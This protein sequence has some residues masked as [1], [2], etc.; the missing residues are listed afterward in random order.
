MWCGFYI[1]KKKTIPIENGTTYNDN[2]TIRASP[3]EKK[4]LR[5][6]ERKVGQFAVP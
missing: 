4:K 3:K 1:N 2:T 5:P 6:K